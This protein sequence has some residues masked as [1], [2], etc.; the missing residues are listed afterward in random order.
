MGGRKKRSANGMRKKE[1]QARKPGYLPELLPIGRK[2]KR[3][4]VF[5][6][7]GRRGGKAVLSL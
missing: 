4:G 7:S 5:E 2:R 6:G 1:S 3:E